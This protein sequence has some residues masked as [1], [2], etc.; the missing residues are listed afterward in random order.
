M[1]W[2]LDEERRVRLILDRV[3]IPRV[4]DRIIASWRQNLSVTVAYERAKEI[5]KLHDR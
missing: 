3:Y 2:T 4:V 5:A 1:T